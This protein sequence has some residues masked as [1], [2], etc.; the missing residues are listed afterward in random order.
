MPIQKEE[1]SSFNNFLRKNRIPSSRAM[2]NKAIRKY[3]QEKSTITPDLLRKNFSQIISDCIQIENNMFD[4]IMNEIR[5]SWGIDLFD[6]QNRHHAFPE[7]S[8]LADESLAAINSNDS[9]EKKLANVIKALQEVNDG[10][11]F[12]MKQSGKTRAGAALQNYLESFFDVLGFEYERQQPIRSGEVLD[13]VFPNLPFLKKQHQDSIIMECQTT[14]KDRFRLSL[15]KAHAQVGTTKFIATLTG[16]NII[17]SSDH[18][19]I[20]TAKLNEIRDDH[21]RLIALKEVSEKWNSPT[22]ISFEEFVNT[23]YPNRSNL[24]ASNV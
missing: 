5:E 1:M 14:L 19:D 8:R 4:D 20:T 2:S 21:W 18:Q 22:V 15:G 3:E 13:L 6:N 23:Q 7:I 24:W 9:A 11:S 12:G 17:T 10:V 16:A